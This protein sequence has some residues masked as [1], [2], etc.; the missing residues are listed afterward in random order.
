M[1]FGAHVSAAGG[2]WH[3]PANSAAIGGDIFQFF[4][5]PP[6]G[7]P[8]PELTSDVVTKFRA[9]MV[10]HHQAASYLHTP[11]FINFASAQTRIAKGSISIVRQEL[12]RGSALGVTA[13]MTHLGSGREVGPDQAVAMTIAGLL[14]VLKGYAGDTTLLLENAA[15]AG[16][17]IGDTFE[18][19][20]AIIAGVLKKIPKVNIGVCLDTCHAFASGYNLRT[21]KDVDA[22]LKAFD[23]AIGLKFLQLLHLNDSQVALGERKDRHAD[24]GDG[25]IGRDGFAALVT[26]PK[27]KKINGILETPSDAQRPKDLA[28]L[29]KTA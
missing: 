17:I 11:Y 1:L 2:A 6:Q 9:A 19:V 13:I 14:E 7:G 3:A 26:H 29:K 8:A 4:S 25:Q 15:G 23:R 18:E 28:W 12:E 21:A 10:E 20:G 27:L 16:A 5:R 24:L 22:T